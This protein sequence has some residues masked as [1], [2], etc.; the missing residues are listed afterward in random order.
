MVVQLQMQVQE[1][2][3]LIKNLQANANKVK[4][5]I[6]PP[7]A[8]PV[9]NR[10][11]QNEKVK[12]ASYNLMDDARIWWEGIELSRDMRNLSMTEAAKRFNQLARL[13]PHMVPNEE[14]WLRRMIGMLRPKIAV[15][16]DSATAPP[17]TTTECVKCALRAE[18]HLNKK[19]ESQ[20]RQS[21]VPKNNNNSRNCGNFR[22]QGRSHGGQW[23]Q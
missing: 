13:C 11:V 8:Q 5:P 23:K 22:N 14:E 7:I 17:I 10:G 15:I 2:Q 4:V 16:V 12:C 6:D 9:Q 1:Q 21:E 20:P 18:Y 19:K 3:I